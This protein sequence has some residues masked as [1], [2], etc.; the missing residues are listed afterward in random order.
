[1]IDMEEL[2][3]RQDQN[4]LVDWIE[5]SGLCRSSSSRR[6]FLIQIELKP[7]ENNVEIAEHDFIVDLI[8]RLV[9]SRNTEILGSILKQLSSSPFCNHQKLRYL[10]ARL[11]LGNYRPSQPKARPA[12]FVDN[13]VFRLMPLDIGTIWGLQRSSFIG[14]LAGFEQDEIYETLRNVEFVLSEALSEEQLKANGCS[15]LPKRE[16]IQLDLSKSDGIPYN[17][18][19]IL[20]VAVNFS[21]EAAKSLKEKN[22]PPLSIPGFLFKINY[23]EINDYLPK[24]KNW[25]EALLGELFSSSESVAIVIDITYSIDENIPQSLQDITQ[26]LQDIKSQ[27]IKVCGPIPIELMHLDYRLHPQQENLSQCMDEWVK[28]DAE[29]QSPEAVRGAFT[30]ISEAKLLSDILMDVWVNAIDFDK[31]HFN[32]FCQNG[33]LNPDFNQT[34]NL[35]LENLTLALLR[36]YNDQPDSSLKA[37]INKLVVSYP[38]LQDFNNFCQ[39]TKE[40]EDDFLYQNDAKQFE[41]ALRANIKLEKAIEKFKAAP[42]SYVPTAIC[43]LL[44]ASPPTKS[45]IYKILLLDPKKRAIFGLCTPQE[46]QKI[47]KRQDKERQVLDCRRKRPLIYSYSL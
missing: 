28:G 7:E 36:K 2:L 13:R 29:S 32:L 41:F 47:K 45:S 43:W 10:E 4:K 27:L 25:C 3:N 33:I 12:Y 19:D 46:W 16:W 24:I 5:S 23:K 34:K 20:D 21:G 40:Q 17:K 11:G 15:P 9:Q 38:T 8:Y 31:F 37:L 35:K 44:A 1:M 30:I 22:F 26:S 42:V 39:N 6:T 14:I 18:S